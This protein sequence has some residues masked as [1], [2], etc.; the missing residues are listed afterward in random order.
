ME[1]DRKKLEDALSKAQTA[2]EQA[3]KAAGKIKFVPAMRDGKKVDF[4]GTVRVTFTLLKR[5]P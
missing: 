2:A 5:Q 4:R 1:A 3:V